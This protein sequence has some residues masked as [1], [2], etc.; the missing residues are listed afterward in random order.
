MP[1]GKPS[2]K[3]GQCYL[4]GGYLVPEL[5]QDEIQKSLKGTHLK[6][7]FEFALMFP[8]PKTQYESTKRKCPICNGNSSPSQETGG[9]LQSRNNF[10]TRRVV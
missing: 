8:V 10:D 5:S 2:V 7:S 1:K 6:V 9:N 3:L 4:P